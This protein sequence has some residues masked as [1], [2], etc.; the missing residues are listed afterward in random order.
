MDSIRKR[1]DASIQDRQ[2][3]EI[4]IEHPTELLQDETDLALEGLSRK[5]VRN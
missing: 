5:C 3:S 2:T 4:Q 1:S